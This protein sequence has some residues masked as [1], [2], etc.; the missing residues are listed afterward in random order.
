MTTKPVVALGDMMIKNARLT[1]AQNLTVAGTV[2]GSEGEPKFNCGLLLGADHPQLKDIRDKMIAIAKE[3]WKEKA[4]AEFKALEKADRLAL[5]DGDLK[6]NYEG[7]P[8]NF[9]LS[10]SAKEIA[11]PTYFGGASGREELDP[12]QAQRVFYS[13]CWVNAKVSFWAQDNGFGKRIN[14]TLLAIQFW[15][16]A[17]AF[18]GGGPREVDANEFDQIEGSDAD[19]FTGASASTEDEFA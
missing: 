10:P 2:P 5:H 7:Y 18:S 9:F 6:P 4:G 13:G 17:D 1:F 19:D 11:R 16:H 3:K 15:K 14:C 12:K 8:G